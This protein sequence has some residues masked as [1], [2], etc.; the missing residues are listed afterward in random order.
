MTAS[1]FILKG[2]ALEHELLDQFQ[3]RAWTLLFGHNSPRENTDDPGRL[4]EI[5]AG[6]NAIASSD[7]LLF[8]RCIREQPIISNSIV[9]LSAKLCI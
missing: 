5:L 3:I 9:Y 1:C 7:C 2:K 6:L 8:Y 4:T